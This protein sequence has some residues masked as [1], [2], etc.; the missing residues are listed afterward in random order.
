MMETKKPVGI[1]RK[2]ILAVLN[3]VTNK[4]AY[5]RAAADIDDCYRQLTALEQRIKQAKY[6]RTC[7][8]MLTAARKDFEDNE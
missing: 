2:E 4:L 8:S 5:C 6:I 3:G 7:G 1:S